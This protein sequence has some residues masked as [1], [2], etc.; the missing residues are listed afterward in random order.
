M[1]SLSGKAAS[2]SEEAI[3]KIQLELNFIQRKKDELKYLNSLNLISASY[4]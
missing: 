3:G 1:M 4:A 2:P